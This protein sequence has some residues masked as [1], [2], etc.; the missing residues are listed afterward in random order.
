MRA[1]STTETTRTSDTFALDALRALWASLA[2]DA[3]VA[4]DALHARDALRAPWAAGSE[5]ALL[6]FW[7]RGSLDGYA[8]R[9][10]A[11][12]YAL[13]N[14][15]SVTHAG[16]ER[17]W[18]PV[19]GPPSTMRRFIGGLGSGSGAGSGASTVIWMAPDSMVVGA[20][21]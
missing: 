6:T 4:V 7:A 16:S 1:S 12:G 19:P 17:T 2:V 3:V 18:M 14:F 11:S 8:S 21:T 10:D 9:E 5:W 20:A 13:S 15:R